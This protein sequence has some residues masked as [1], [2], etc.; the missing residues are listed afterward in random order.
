MENDISVSLEV[1][2]LTPMKI[3]RLSLTCTRRFVEVDYINQALTVSSAKVLSIEEED[4]Y[5]TPLEHDVRRI[6]LR[7][8]EPLKREISDFLRAIKEE[9]EPLV[10]GRDGL[11]AVKICAAALRS[12]KTGR[13]VRV[14]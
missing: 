1:N 14:G 5:Q 3:R 2:W 12:Y 8:Q 9:Q 4:L 7:K 11:A 13:I 10:T 6:V